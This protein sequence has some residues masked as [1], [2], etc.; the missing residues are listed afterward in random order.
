M[1]LAFSGLTDERFEWAGRLGAHVRNYADRMLPVVQRRL[2]YVPGITVH[3]M[4][5]G[6]ARHRRYYG[7]RKI[8]AEFDY[9]PLTDIARGPDGMWQWASDKPAFHRAVREYFE[10]RHEDPTWWQ[11]MLGRRFG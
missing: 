2:G 4:W 3:H 5:H 7:R 11:R 8:L 9:D 1:A 6:D 10:Q